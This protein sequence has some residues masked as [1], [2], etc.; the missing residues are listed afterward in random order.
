VRCG[1]RLF[2]VGRWHGGHAAGG[3]DDRAGRASMT[4]L[5]ISP[6]TAA[7]TVSNHFFTQ[8]TDGTHGVTTNSSTYSSKYGL[9]ANLLGTLA[10][11]FS[12]AGSGCQSSRRR[13]LRQ[14]QCR[15]DV[16]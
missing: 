5:E 9:D 16:P 8:I 13:R 11:A 3:V 6:T 15:I 10:Q 7:N 1:P 2:V 12:T 4:P 14:V